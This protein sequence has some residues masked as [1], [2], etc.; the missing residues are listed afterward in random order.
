VEEHGPGGSAVAEL[1]ALPAF[2]CSGCGACCMD[3][4]HIPELVQYADPT[5]GRCSNLGPDDKTCM[6]YADRPLVC[7]VDDLGK[8]IRLTPRSWR[9]LNRQSCML[10][11]RQHHNGEELEPIGQQC[12]HGRPRATAPLPVP[13]LPLRDR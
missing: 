10:L 11:H 2:P 5:T 9:W 13:F 8:L 7:R 4:R 6:V 3:V 12:L 1:E